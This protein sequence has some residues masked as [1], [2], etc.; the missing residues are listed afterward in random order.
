MICGAIIP[1]AMY[2]IIILLNIIPDLEIQLNSVLLLEELKTL[3][4]IKLTDVGIPFFI[5]GQSL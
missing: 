5:V 2:L 4:K 1:A 3:I